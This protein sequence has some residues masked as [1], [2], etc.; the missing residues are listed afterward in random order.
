[1]LPTAPWAHPGRV[2]SADLD[3][4]TRADVLKIVPTVDGASEGMQ[5]Q[6]LGPSPWTAAIYRPTTSGRDFRT[7]IDGFDLGS[8]YG[9][10]ASQA[11]IATQPMTDAA[12]FLWFDDVWTQHFQLCARRGPIIG[13]G[14]GPGVDGRAFANA[15]LGSYP[16]PAFA[17]RNVTLR[18][19]LAKA[20]PVTI[21][22]YNVAGREVANFNQK[23][24]AGANSV[25]WNGAL[26]NGAK[27]T[28]GVY[29]YAIDGVDFVKNASKAQKMILL[30]ANEAQ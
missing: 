3:C 4:L 9:Q 23:G 21:R 15:N 28:A 30:G 22:I 5:Y 25:I 26:S 6:N 10:Y 2:Y 14:D 20:Q 29:F 27:A 19:T 16:N 12:R 17:G 18:F 1:M 13:V 8:L 11:Q 7:L 24:V